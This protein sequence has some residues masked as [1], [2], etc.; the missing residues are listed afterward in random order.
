MNNFLLF[1]LFAL[2]GMFVGI[3]LYQLPFLLFYRRAT[4][5]TEEEFVAAVPEKKWVT[6][7]LYVLVP[8]WF[9]LFVVLMMSSDP[10]RNHVITAFFFPVFFS[11]LGAV[12]AVPELVARVG[13]RIPVGHNTGVPVQYTV[14]R[15]AT[16]AGIFRLAEAFVVVTVFLVCR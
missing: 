14:S 16:R 10:N 4:W 13:V 8:L 7:A 12:P 15:N 1:P 2:L 6:R 11:C 5:V 3:L 9:F